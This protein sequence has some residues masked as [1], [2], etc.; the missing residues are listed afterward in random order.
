MFYS[1][2]QSA[3]DMNWNHLNRK[4]RKRLICRTKFLHSTSRFSFRF[5]S[6]SNV[7]R[8]VRQENSSFF[9]RTAEHIIAE[10][11]AKR[12]RILFT[13]C[14][15]FSSR[16]NGSSMR[17]IHFCGRSLD[18]LLT[19]CELAWVSECLCVCANATQFLFFFVFHLN[20]ITRT[21]NDEETK[22]KECKG[23]QWLHSSSFFSIVYF[24]YGIAW[25]HDVCVAALNNNN[26]HG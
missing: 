13:F 12:Q 25:C 21:W 20:A 4:I 7:A 19:L 22:E 23:F 14:I 2:H 6:W 18:A 3:D 5:D 9:E 10:S 1:F 16:S 24:H 11:R 8:E 17:C 15:F 26:N